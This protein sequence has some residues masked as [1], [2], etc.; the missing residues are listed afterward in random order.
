MRRSRQDSIRDLLRIHSD[1]LSQKQISKILGIPLSKVCLVVKAMPDVYVDRW[2]Q[3]IGGQFQKIF[4][5]QQIPEDCPHPIDAYL[6]D[7]HG[8]I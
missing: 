1:G 4:V 3:L 6:K 7:W 8:E 5:A 2:Q